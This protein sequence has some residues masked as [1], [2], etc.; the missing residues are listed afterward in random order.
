MEPNIREAVPEDAGD[1]VRLLA[2]VA[3]EN[4]WIRTELPFDEAERERRMMVA[5][6]A[7]D[8]VSFVARTDTTTVGEVTLRF[9]EDRAALAMVVAAAHRGRGLGRALMAFA[10]AKA[11]ERGASRI[12]LAVYSHNLPA[13]ALL[14]SLDFVETGSPIPEQRSDGQRWEAIPMSKYLAGR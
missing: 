10:V 12:D 3:A 11:R 1:I 13:L 6:K 5:M 7:G 4:M 8:M 14:R 2:G 9:R